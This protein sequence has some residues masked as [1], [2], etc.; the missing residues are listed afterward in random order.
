MNRGQRLVQLRAFDQPEKLVEVLAGML[1][2]QKAEEAGAA[3]AGVPAASTRDVP[4]RQQQT[5]SPA[6][7]ASSSSSAAPASTEAPARAK[8]T[9]VPTQRKYDF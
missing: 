1:D 3:A 9:V 8:P 2:A 6:S 5:T 4:P 7:S